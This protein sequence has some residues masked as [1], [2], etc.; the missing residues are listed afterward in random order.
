[1]NGILFSVG[2]PDIKD[3]YGSNSLYVDIILESMIR[4]LESIDTGRLSAK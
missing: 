2:S 4:K 3:K 1:M